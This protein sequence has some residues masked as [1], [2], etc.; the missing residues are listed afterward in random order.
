MFLFCFFRCLVVCLFV[1]LFV[2]LFCS[3]VFVLHML[4]M[5][6]GLLGG[7]LDLI[8][9]DPAL[10][11]HEFAVA[12]SGIADSDHYMVGASVYSTTFN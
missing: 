9:L 11:I 3:G 6:I 1:C 4:P 10:V 2:F 8:L 7:V 5:V 12:D